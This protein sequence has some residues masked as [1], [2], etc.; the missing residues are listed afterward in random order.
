M[1]LFALHSSSPLS[2]SIR[3]VRFEFCDSGDWV[4]DRVECCFL[5]GMV[6]GVLGLATRR[7]CDDLVCCLP[8][9]TDHRDWKPVWRIGYCDKSF[10]CGSVDACFVRWHDM[11]IRVYDIVDKLGS[12]IVLGV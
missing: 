5:H 12:C 4:I 8:I 6:T 10:S 9:C 1:S 11:F 7:W 2:A 3:M